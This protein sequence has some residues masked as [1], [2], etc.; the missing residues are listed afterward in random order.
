MALFKVILNQNYFQYDGKYFKAIEDTAMALP[1]SGFIVELHLQYFEELSIR[2]WLESREILDDFLI[3][4]EQTKT[5]EWAISMYMNI[6]HKH[7]KFKV[8][9]EESKNIN[10][11]DLSISRYNNSLSLRIYRKPTQ[12]DTTILYVQ[13]SYAA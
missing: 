12:T 11:K 9:E 2:H 4:H 1:I 5:N 13:P 6:V 7:L 3:I 10:Y 8:T